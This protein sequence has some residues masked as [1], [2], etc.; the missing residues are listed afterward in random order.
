MEPVDEILQ[1]RNIIF[2]VMLLVSC[3]VALIKNKMT[4]NIY[5]IVLTA[6]IAILTAVAKWC[7]EMR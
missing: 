4:L 6:L 5:Q 7:R 2:T 1:R 3:F